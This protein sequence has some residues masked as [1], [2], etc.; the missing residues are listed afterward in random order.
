MNKQAHA[1]LP[2]PNSKLSFNSR[3]YKSQFM[4]PFTIYADYE[5]VQEKSTD[6]ETRNV[7]SIHIP[8]Q[9]GF[10][11]VNKHSKNEY[12]YFTGR[13]ADQYFVDQLIKRVIT[14]CDSIYNQFYEKRIYAV[15][16]VLSVND[17]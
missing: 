7:R 14:D 4:H 12:H 8:S 1:K 16:E 5:T 15:P 3:D 13:K 17:R 11:I 6:L 2:P 10:Y 9:V